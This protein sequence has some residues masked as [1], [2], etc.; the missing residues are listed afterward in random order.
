MLPSLLPRAIV[1]KYDEALNFVTKMAVYQ[2]RRAAIATILVTVKQ[3]DICEEL[4]GRHKR[5]GKNVPQTL[6]GLVL[7]IKLPLHFS[8]P[9][10]LEFFAFLTFSLSASLSSEYSSKLLLCCSSQEDGNRFHRKMA[11][12]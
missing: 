11:M 7:H 10:F 1:N 6:P 9:G 3:D 4:L 8:L 2:P 5:N 12:R